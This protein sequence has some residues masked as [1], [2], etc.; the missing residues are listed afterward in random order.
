MNPFADRGYISI[1]MPY[2]LNMAHNV[3]RAMSQ[4]ARGGTDLK[5]GN[6]IV[7]TTIDTLSPI[8]GV[9]DYGIDNAVA[10]T[11]AD[12]FIDVISNE[13][14]TG[15]PVFKEGFRGIELRH[16]NCIG[17]QLHHPQNG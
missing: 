15:K 5:G 4:L 17:L 16:L 7:G 1:P 8:G 9:W 10:P 13:D 6:S 2:G 11:I 14:F 3:G 12:P